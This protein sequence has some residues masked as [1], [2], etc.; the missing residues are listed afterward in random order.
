MFTSLTTSS[1]V[2]LHLTRVLTWGAALVLTSGASFVLSCCADCILTC[3]VDCVLTGVRTSDATSAQTY[4]AVHRDESTYHWAPTSR[5]LNKEQ[6]AKNGNRAGKGGIKVG[7][8]NC[9]R[10]LLD[11]LG[12]PTDKLDEIAAYIEL[13]DI[14]IMAIAEAGLHGLRSRTQRS[15]PL[16]EPEIQDALRIPGFHIIL[17]AS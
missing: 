8:W 3:N 4:A 17:P 7:G 6:H 15:K 16:T 5:E 11:Q 12:N 10:G 9:N 2:P 14:Q 13:H 1:P